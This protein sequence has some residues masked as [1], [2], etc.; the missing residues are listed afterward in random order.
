MRRP[1]PL[2]RL[3][4]PR[5]SRNDALFRVYGAGARFAH[6]ALITAG[7]VLLVPL[8][9][10]A[11]YLV[12]RPATTVAK[13][14]GEPTAAAGGTPVVEGAPEATGGNAP[15]SPEG[16]VVAGG[17]K[18]PVKGFQPPPEQTI[19][20]NEYGETIRLAALF[21]AAQGALAH[22]K[23]LESS[24]TP[25]AALARAPEL[26][27]LR[28][29][30]EPEQAFASVELFHDGKWSALATQVRTTSVLAAVPRLVS[31]SHR[32]RWRVMSRDGH[33]Q[34]GTFHFTVR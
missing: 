2:L 17:A 9:L 33:R 1:H 10:G 26:I 32:I 22:V 27:V 13:S 19:P 16:A 24:P 15:P 28:F 8:A 18:A 11:I 34:L 29:S 25:G 6:A 7:A 31:G 14:S 12:D 20:D 5:R 3:P 23:L 30:S 4:A 21:F